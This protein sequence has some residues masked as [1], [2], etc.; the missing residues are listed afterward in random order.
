[1]NF[2]PRERGRVRLLS[3]NYQNQC[4]VVVQLHARMTPGSPMLCTLLV[5][6][7]SVF[8][9]VKCSDVEP[10]AGFVGLKVA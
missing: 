10:V 5:D 1:M 2:I 6:N 4:G 7:T 3:G 9:T 8:L